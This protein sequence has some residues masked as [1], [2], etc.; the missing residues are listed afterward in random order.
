MSE[1]RTGTRWASSALPKLKNPEM[2]P[3][4]TARS[5]LFWLGLG[6]ATFAVIVVGYG[7]GFWSSRPTPGS[8]LRA[9][10]RAFLKRLRRQSRSVD[11]DPR[12]ERR[13]SALEGPR[14]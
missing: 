14:H 13:R 9:L 4:S 1:V 2:D 6:V 10:S 12:A 7:T 5:I 3:T 8:F 11:R